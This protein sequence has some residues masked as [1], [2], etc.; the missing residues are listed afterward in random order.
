MY[1][2]IKD[3]EFLSKLHSTCADIVNQL[4]VEINKDS[5][6][7]VSAYLVGSGAKKLITQNGNQE[8]DLDYNLE[9]MKTA[10]N[11]CRDIK[12]YIMDMF[13]VVLERKGWGNCQDSTSV[14]STEYR[15]FKQ[16]NRTG[17]FTMSVSKMQGKE[18]PFGMTTEQLCQRFADKPKVTEQHKELAEKYN[19]NAEDLAYRVTTPSFIN[20]NYEVSSVMEML[21]LEFTKM[22]ELNI[23]FRKCKRCGRYFIMKGNY[24]TNYCDRIAEGETKNCQDIMAMENYKKK[25]ADNA[26]ITI[27]NKYYKRYFARVKAHTIL[28]DDFKKWKYEAIVKRDQCSDGEI[29]NEEFTAWLDSCFPNRKRKH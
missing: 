12:N 4:V 24:D 21:E 16:G 6:M 19:M 11:N 7:K 23:R 9:I 17:T 5:V 10:L 8:V 15:E 26:A 2:Y 22:L 1:H 27:Y 29:T 13:D 25:I 28:E 14:I 20:I 18:M 3:K